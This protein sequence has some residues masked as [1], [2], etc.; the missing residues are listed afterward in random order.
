MKLNKSYIVL[1]LICIIG[2]FLFMFPLIGNYW[3]SKHSSRAIIEYDE[4]TQKYD[5]EDA[6]KI[7]DEVNSY[8]LSLLKRKDEF[9]LEKEQLEKY[10]SLLNIDGYGKMG[11]IEIPKIGISIPIYH[12]I[13]EETL[14]NNVGHLE[15]S[16]LPVG[17][18]STHSV[19]SAHNGLI[20]SKLFTDLW[21]L[22]EG[23]KFIIHVLNDK[24]IY[25]VDQINTVKPN[26][27]NFLKIED[28]KDLATL[29]TCTPYGINTERLL[30][31]GHRIIDNKEYSSFSSNASKANIFIEAGI[32]SII[33]LIIFIIIV[34]KNKK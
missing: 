25:E 19:L 8:N 1:I 10:N 13:S 22:K 17:G 18:A 15:W 23:D 30:V 27:N 12:G 20:T 26:D 4:Q 5:Q 34:A 29:I 2:L 16:S 6:K 31:R 33:P 3:N 9:K 21:K 28:G 32:F 11:Y 24:L 14:S 7:L